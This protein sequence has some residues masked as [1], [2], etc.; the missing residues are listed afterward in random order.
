MRDLEYLLLI[1]FFI[2]SIFFWIRYT[3]KNYKNT[4]DDIT[5]TKTDVDSNSTYVEFYEY[6][7]AYVNLNTLEP[8]DDEV[9]LYV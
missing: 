7:D 4:I 5:G 3:D 9:V 8:V 1:F 2:T 6:S